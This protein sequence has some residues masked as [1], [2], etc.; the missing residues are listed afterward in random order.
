MPTL[1]H[2]N[3]SARDDLS[4]AIIPSDCNRLT[5]DRDE[6]EDR[7]TCQVSF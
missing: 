6:D 5:Q 2:I 3:V 4:F 7:D 1:I